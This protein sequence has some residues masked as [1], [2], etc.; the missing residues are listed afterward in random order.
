[1]LIMKKWEAIQQ[2]AQVLYQKT[3]SD[4]KRAAKTDPSA[5]DN[6]VEKVNNK[7]IDDLVLEVVAQYHR[8]AV[9]GYADLAFPHKGS[10]MTN[11]STTHEVKRYDEFDCPNCNQVCAPEKYKTHLWTC[12]KLR[13][14]GSRRST[15]RATPVSMKETSD[16]CPSTGTSDDGDYDDW[17]ATPTSQTKKKKITQKSKNHK[18]VRFNV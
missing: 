11:G 14:V 17:S 4:V 1:M 15:V 3:R 13:R 12:M 10:A 7:M 16:P 18:K 2:E 6:F 5:S 8:A 9:K